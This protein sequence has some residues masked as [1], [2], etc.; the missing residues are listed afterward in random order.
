MKLCIG[1]Q[2]CM[3]LQVQFPPK[4]A[5]LLIIVHCGWGWWHLEFTI[6]WRITCFLFLL[7]ITLNCNGSLNKIW[8]VFIARR[9]GRKPQSRM[10]LC[11]CCFFQVGKKKSLYLFLWMLFS[12][13]NHLLQMAFASGEKF[14]NSLSWNCIVTSTLTSRCCTQFPACSFPLTILK[15]QLHSFDYLLFIRETFCYSDKFTLEGMTFSEGEDGIL[16][17][18]TVC[19][20]L[21][22]SLLC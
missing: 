18:L 6:T 13:Q 8:V 1:E 20:L 5:P 19:F 2:A 7:D 11:C 10:V 16:K 15:S 14:W 9:T 21:I 22:Y 4:K 3:V 12:C 17:P